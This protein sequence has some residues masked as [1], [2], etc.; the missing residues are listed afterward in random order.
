M[1]DKREY[2]RQYQKKRRADP[3]V[4]KKDYAASKAWYRRIK[5]EVQ[6]MREERK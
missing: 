3:D 5:Q 2:D 6:R 1:Q 4:R